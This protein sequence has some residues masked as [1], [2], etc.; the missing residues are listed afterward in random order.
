MKIS[1][2]HL[3]AAAFVALVAAG[4]TSA[5]SRFY[6]LSSTAATDGSP[7]LSCVVAIDPVSIPAEADRSQFTVQ[8]GPNQVEV[9][10]FNRW[11]APLN[12]A[13]ARAIAGD[14]S[15]QLGTPRVASA[16]LA[17]FN[18]DYR[19]AISIQRFESVSG[20]SA[21]VEALWVVRKQGAAAAV[22][23]R[24]IASETVANESFDALT[25][26]HSRALA[27]VSSAIAAAIRAKA[28][29]KPTP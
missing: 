7:A 10:E 26:A 23:G 16:Q 20:K 24:T 2:H 15:V 13:I 28:D 27:K 6:T 11:A 5:P 29:E 18:P 3:I 1:I 19:V 25:A 17:N 22:S 9:N 4:C 8:V 12:E 14:L 21:L